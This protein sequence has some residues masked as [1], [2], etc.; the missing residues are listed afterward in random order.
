MLQGKIDRALLTP[1]AEAFF[2]RQTLADASASL[3]GQGP[4][5]SLKQTSVEQRGGMTYRH[6]E[7]K[8]R[9]KSLHL[10][11]LMVPGGK[12]EQYLIQ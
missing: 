6:F 7:V 3:R 11:T 12:L 2:T 8:F 5:V 10:S 1:N 4:L 9:T